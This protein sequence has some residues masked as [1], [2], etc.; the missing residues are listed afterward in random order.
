MYLDIKFMLTL[1]SCILFYTAIC[2][3]VTSGAF[4]AYYLCDKTIEPVKL[5]M[6]ISW[7]IFGSSVLFLLIIMF[8]INR[9]KKNDEHIT[10][11]EYNPRE[12][13]MT[14]DTGDLISV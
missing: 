14:V 7:S 9:N 11:F 3:L 1:M 12:S 8:F 13:L 10:E 2:S 4:T 6:I 5:S